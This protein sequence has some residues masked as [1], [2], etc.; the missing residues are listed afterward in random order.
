MD[1]K[2]RI[3]EQAATMFFRY[4]IRSITMDEI[5]ESLGI[6]KRTLY[7]SY[8][9]KEELLMHCIE[10]KYQ[11]NKQI[12]ESLLN[13]YPDNIL[14]AIYQHFRL[15][16]IT[17]G[18]IHPN[19]FNDLKK[20]HSKIWKHHIESKQEENIEFTRAL[21]EKGISEGYFIESADPE[22]LARIS[23]SLMQTMSL[24]NIFPETRFPK[25]EVVKQSLINFIR[26][27]ATEKG[28][29]FIDEKFLSI[30]ESSL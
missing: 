3:V 25:A 23:H 5:A 9:N 13:E 6:S 29:R 22:I 12:R 20:Y 28:I 26:G 21:I 8:S 7:E 18:S 10:H 14:E 11:E 24:T 4:G 30:Q 1:T 15:A 19:F 17:L 16:I 2:Q 27:M